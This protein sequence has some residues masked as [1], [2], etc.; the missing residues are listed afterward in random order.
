MPPEYPV[1]VA[2]G[3]W[4]PLPTLLTGPSEYSASCLATSSS[5]IDGAFASPRFITLHASPQVNNR[6]RSSCHLAHLF[7]CPSIQLGPMTSYTHFRFLYIRNSALAHVNS[8]V[9]LS[10]VEGS[11]RDALADMLQ[12]S[13]TIA[14]LLPRA[15]MGVAPPLVIYP[16]VWVIAP[17]CSTEYHTT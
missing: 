17:R 6:L 12:N 1:L 4:L 14:T 10:Y 13:L 3:S 16:R 2:T 7:I 5:T 9:I 11:L 15:G 8:N